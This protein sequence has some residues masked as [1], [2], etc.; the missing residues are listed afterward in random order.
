MHAPAVLVEVC[1]EAVEV[2]HKLGSVKLARSHSLA[3]LLYRHHIQVKFRQSEVQPLLAPTSL[4]TVA[5]TNNLR[6]EREISQNYES[7]RPLRG[8][9]KSSREGVSRALGIHEY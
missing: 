3:V 7:V 9:K 2:I 4:L 6:K 1:D 5:S 8:L